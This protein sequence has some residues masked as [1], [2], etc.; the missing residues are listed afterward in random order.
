M[1]AL[2]TLASVW[3]RLP[4]APR[5]PSTRSRSGLLARNFLIVAGGRKSG[6]AWC[7]ASHAAVGDPVVAC[8]ATDRFLRHRSGAS[9][10]RHGLAAPG[11]TLQAWRHP[12]DT[13]NTAA[14]VPPVPL[15][16]GTIALLWSVCRRARATQL[17]VA[18]TGYPTRRR[19]VTPPL[20]VFM[21]S[22]PCVGSKEHQ[23]PRI[24]TDEI[25]IDI[26]TTS[27]AA[28][29]MR[30]RL[31]GFIKDEDVGLGDAIKRVTYA[32]GL[33]PFGGCEQR[34]AALIRGW[35]SPGAGGR[36]SLKGRM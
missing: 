31:P 21:G 19:S 4:R 26:E 9:I 33:Q 16:S 14:A 35:S 10:G 28:S 15:V 25:P 12:G 8:D 34:A 18:V 6:H 2:L 24:M 11:P 5:R 3:P 1:L 29:P 20:L 13:R 17:R 23:D 30:V 32:V 36:N 27:R 22:V 7:S